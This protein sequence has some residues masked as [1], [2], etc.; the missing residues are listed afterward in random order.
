MALQQ[1]YTEIVSEDND[2]CGI[3]SYI[4]NARGVK[5]VIYPHPYDIELDE[6][7][8]PAWQFDLGLKQEPKELEDTSLTIIDQVTFF[9]DI[10]W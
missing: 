5:D 1:E 3:T 2:S 10:S 6:L 7:E 9:I 4:R 8:R